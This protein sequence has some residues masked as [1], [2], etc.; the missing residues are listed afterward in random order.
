VIG[1]EEARTRGLG[2]AR[3]AIIILTTYTLTALGALV[4]WVMCR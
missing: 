3:G 1:H 2:P 4:G